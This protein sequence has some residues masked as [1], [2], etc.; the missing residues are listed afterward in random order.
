MH[1]SLTS[2]LVPTKNCC[3]LR[4]LP[5]LVFYILHNFVLFFHCKILPSFMI[6]TL[7]FSSWHYNV[8]FFRKSNLF[9]C[10]ELQFERNSSYKWEAIDDKTTSTP[11]KTSTGKTFCF[12]SF[13]QSLDTRLVKIR[14]KHLISNVHILFHSI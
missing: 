3:F 11:S 13:P 8:C 1:P 10:L 5:F 4:M 7:I 9:S 12:L 14:I 2:L 6:A